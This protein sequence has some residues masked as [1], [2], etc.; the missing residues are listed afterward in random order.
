MTPDQ[1][2]PYVDVFWNYLPSE[3][4]YTVFRDR[5]SYTVFKKKS[6]L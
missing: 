2:K 1:F 6:L 5:D 3:A 4:E